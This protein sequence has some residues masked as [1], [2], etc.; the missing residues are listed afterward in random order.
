MK[1]KINLREIKQNLCFLWKWVNNQIYTLL[2]EASKHFLSRLVK[3]APQW[4]QDCSPGPTCRP[5][6]RPTFKV[7]KRTKG[8]FIA[9][10]LQG[11]KVENGYLFPL[12]HTCLIIC[13]G[14][15]NWRPALCMNETPLLFGNSWRDFSPP[16]AQLQCG[17]SPSSVRA[18]ATHIPHTQALGTIAL[19]YQNLRATIASAMCFCLSCFPFI[20]MC[21]SSIFHCCHFTNGTNTLSKQAP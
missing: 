2:T 8:S 14:M 21:F 5:R 18:C 9:P 4:S 11:L 7:H 10:S 16:D 1:S 12:R 6:C 19:I 17:P 3:R 15:H 13:M 20:K